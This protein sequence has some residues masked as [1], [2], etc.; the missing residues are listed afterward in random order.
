MQIVN[1]GAFQ[2]KLIQDFW[3]QKISQQL[4]VPGSPEGKNGLDKGDNEVA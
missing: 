4:F 3:G 2:L 1:K